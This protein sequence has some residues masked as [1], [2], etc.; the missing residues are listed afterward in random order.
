M[1]VSAS[2]STGRPSGITG[3]SL[4]ALNRRCSHWGGISLTAV[5][6]TASE[7]LQAISMPT[8]VIKAA[9]P[10]LRRHAST[11][12]AINAGS[13]TQAPSSKR[14]LMCMPRIRSNRLIPGSSA[15]MP[16]MAFPHSTATA[17]S[18]APSGQAKCRWA[19]CPLIIAVMVPPARIIAASHE[20]TMK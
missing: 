7:L 12:A 17:S 10:S 6:Q 11:R 13:V 15:P 9:K 5:F 4:N 18:A 20:N 16:E 19:R 1:R 2:E 8:S 14:L 3:P